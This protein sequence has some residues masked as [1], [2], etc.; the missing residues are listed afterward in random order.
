[1]PADYVTTGPD[2]DAVFDRMSEIM[3][4]IT[5]TRRDRTI[6]EYDALLCVTVLVAAASRGIEPTP[7]NLRRMLRIVCDRIVPAL[8]AEFGGWGGRI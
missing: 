4:L 8:D 6:V 5:P 7:D 3:S 1:M 2:V